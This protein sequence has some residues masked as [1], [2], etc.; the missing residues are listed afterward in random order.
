MDLL[1]LA[2]FNLVARHGGFGLAARAAGRPKA[3][4]SRR[5]G[6]LEAS[7]GVRLFERGGSRPRL[8]GPGAAL[9]LRTAQLLAEIDEAADTVASQGDRPRGRLRISAPVL[10]AQA[11]MGR[12]AADFALLHPE[13]GVEATAE[14]R[15]V[16]LVEEGYDLVIRVNPPGEGSLVGRR[17]LRDRLVVVAAPT[18]ERPGGDGPVRAVLLGGADALAPWTIGSG[19]GRRDLPLTPVM[20]LSSLFMVRDAVR[21]GAG[22]GLLPLSLV[23]RDIAQ[24]VLEHWGDAE[25]RAV[26]LWALHTSRRLPSPKVSAFLQHLQ[27][28]FPLGT[29]EELAGFMVEP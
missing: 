22:A 4:L 6:E 10:F 28:A 23:A 27:R 25:S 11:A 26:E 12:L 13:V 19:A 20:R 7:L 24:G 5:V 9:H 15:T 16:D 1:A 17:L 3:T 8:T 2:D 18:V 14:D 29:S 21:A